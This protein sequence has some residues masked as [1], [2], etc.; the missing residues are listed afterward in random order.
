MQDQYSI[1]IV[2]D[3][4]AIRDS[5]PAV[6]DF[7]QFGFRV[8]QT[9]RNGQDALEK[10]KKEHPDVLLLDIR[11]PIL[12]G[13]GLLKILAEEMKEYHPFVIMLSGYSD[14]EY[15]RTAIRYGVKA[16]LT[17]PLDEDELIKEL[18][19][20]RAELDE[21]H[22]HRANAKLLTQA[23]VVKNMLYSEKPGMRELMRGTFLMH[24]VILKD[25]FKGA[26]KDTLKEAVSREQK[27]P[28]EAVRSCIEMELE[29][30]QCVF[31]R[32][33]GCVLTYLVAE[34]CLN[35]Y[36]SSVNLLGRH[37]HHQLKSQGIS[38]AILLDEH[39]F[40]PSEN[41]FRSDYDRHLYAL[42]T[43]VF[44]S[45]ETVVSDPNISGQ[46]QFLEQEK[47][48][49]E[50][51]R[52]AFSKDDKEAAVRCMEALLSQAVQKKLNIVM[53][54]E[55]NYR[56][57][58]LLQ[59][60]LQKAQNAQKIQTIQN[61]QKAQI[62]NDP[63]IQ[64]DAPVCLTT[65]DWRENT[66][67]LRHEEWEAAVKHQFL[68]AADCLT[69]G[70]VDEKS[71][72]SQVL[73]YIKKHFKEPLSAKE[74]AAHFFISPVYLGRVIQQA[75]GETFKQYVNRL[76]ME[77]AKRL[78]LSSNRL[79]YEIA[80]EVGFRDSKYFISRFTEEMGMSP[81]EYRRKKEKE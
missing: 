25:T 71:T 17:K 48:G 65:F 69:T 27:A 23:D 9:A 30:E 73:S 62:Q 3:E 78:L 60:L 54:Q 55:L 80:E 46:V 59:D 79:I 44:W 39:I 11:M 4:K 81:A 6:V 28:Y 14:F 67:Y 26:F 68:I 1:M 40:A 31:V 63:R 21:R 5:L 32:S 43:R 2:D 57:F 38:C 42:M 12:D 66:W 29:A 51:I 47:E 7:E 56:F 19:E 16:Y 75:S 10:I 58:Y 8:C 61:V 64:T 24:C 20:L 77:E 50:A 22:V 36:Q 13:L 70:S 45:E 41:R 34:D 74:V 49:F 72:A 76:K 53:I 35:A 15:A 52:T 37:L 33:R 18:E